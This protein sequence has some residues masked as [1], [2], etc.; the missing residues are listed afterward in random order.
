MVEREKCRC[1]GEEE[2]AGSTFVLLAGRDQAVEEYPCTRE[3]N[4][5]EN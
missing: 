4:D 1:G 2:A 3:T 5:R